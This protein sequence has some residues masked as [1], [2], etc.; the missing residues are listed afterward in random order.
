[1]HIQL[2]VG[3]ARIVVPDNVCV[4]SRAQIGAGAVALF[5]HNPHGGVDLDWEDAPRA[6]AGTTRLVVDADIGLGALE[7][8]HTDAGFHGPRHFDGTSAA[9]AVGNRACAV[10]GTTS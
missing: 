7:V 4:V 9:D 10:G 2:G 3:D 1:M 5:D 8:R 6:P